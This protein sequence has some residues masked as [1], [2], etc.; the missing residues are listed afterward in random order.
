MLARWLL[1]ARMKRMPAFAEFKG[2][3]SIEE[4]HGLDEV[5]ISGVFVCMCARVCVFFVSI[6]RA[7]RLTS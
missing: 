4:L 5:S 3:W 6:A 1:M 7:S 2:P